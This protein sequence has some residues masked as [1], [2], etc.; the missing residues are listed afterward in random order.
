MS[1]WELVYV[2][3]WELVYVSCWELVYVLLGVSVCLVGTN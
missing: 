3:R 2:S 1:C